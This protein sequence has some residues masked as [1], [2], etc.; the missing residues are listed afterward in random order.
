MKL[1]MLRILLI[2][3]I[4]N[5]FFYYLLDLLDERVHQNEVSKLL[6]IK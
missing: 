2:I 4:L 1:K 5:L 6:V 3:K